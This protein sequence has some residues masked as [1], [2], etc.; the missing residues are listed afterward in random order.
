VSFLYI[1]Q[2]NCICKEQTAGSHLIEG[3]SKWS[4]TNPR[5]KNQREDYDDAIAAASA[6]P[7]ANYISVV[8]ICNSTSPSLTDPPS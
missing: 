8:S 3:R 7:S 2:I 4:F 5:E 6:V 1:V